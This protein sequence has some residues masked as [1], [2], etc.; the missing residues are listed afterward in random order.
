MTKDQENR[1]REEFAQKFKCIQSDCDGAGNIP[2]QIN[3][4]VWEANQCQFH[5]EYLF[6]I[7]D[8]SLTKMKEQ[9]EITVR[10]ERKNGQKVR[11]C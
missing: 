5:A 6:P 9:I 2:Y 10:E 7:Y 4:G 1:I 11:I 3:D 8:F